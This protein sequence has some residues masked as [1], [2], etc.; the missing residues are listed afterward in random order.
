MLGKAEGKR[1]REQQRV[2]RLG[3]ITDSKHMN[4][5]ISWEIV[6]DRGDWHAAM[7]NCCD[8]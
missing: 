2:R 4:L 1:R 6:K 3:T 5:S 7:N 8:L